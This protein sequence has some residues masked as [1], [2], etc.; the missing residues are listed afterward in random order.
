M[1]TQVTNIH[2]KTKNM[3]AYSSTHNTVNGKPNQSAKKGRKKKSRK[4]RSHFSEI[5]SCQ[6]Q[7]TT[8][9]KEEGVGGAG[10][11]GSKQESTGHAF[12]LCGHVRS[13]NKADME[14]KK[15]FF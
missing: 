11:G 5:L 12:P 8:G 13:I 14:E 10:G 2:T 15:H 7:Q 6:Q 9:K 3:L 1:K 4:E